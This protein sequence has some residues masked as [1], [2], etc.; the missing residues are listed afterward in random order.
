M[1]SGGVD[2]RRLTVVLVD[3]QHEGNVGATA[4]AMGNLGVASLRLV[5]GVEPGE[6]AERMACASRDVL[7]EARRFETLAEAVADSVL[8]V[9]FVSPE[10]R[11]E[12]PVVDLHGVL[13]RIASTAAGGG[14]VALLFGRE[15]RGLTREEAEACGF[16]ASIPLPSTR[17]TL[18]VAQA[19][20]LAVYEILRPQEVPVPGP[21]P[22]P[23]SH[24]PHARLATVVEREAAM[25]AFDDSL[26]RLGFDEIPRL[27]L[28][29]RLLR[30]FHAIFE[31]AVLDIYDVKMLRGLS[32]RVLRV[33]PRRPGERSPRVPPE[34]HP[35]DEDW[36][37]QL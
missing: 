4:R 18:N 19:A 23:G 13:P 27:R 35:R 36:P 34:D 9:G 7:A 10:R 12:L 26:A 30:R 15:D 16:L 29:E 28:R 1:A 31:R 37:E 33:V 17:H 25:A 32:A 20:L 22:S 11:R 14:S 3:P 6:E 2:P 21:L 8:A 24:R 5:G